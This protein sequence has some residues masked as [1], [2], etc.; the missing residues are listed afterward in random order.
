[1]NIPLP[2]KLDV[3]GNLA[4]NWK[5][6]WRMWDNYEIATKLKEQDKEQRISTLLV[7]IGAEAL[8]IYY[9][10]PWE[11]TVDAE[12]QVTKDEAR[13]IDVVLE[14]LEKYCTGETNEI[15]ERYCF[16][17][18]AQQENETIDA[19]VTALRTTGSDVQLQ[20]IGEQSDP[21]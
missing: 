20:H 10:L 13:D 18:R 1:M 14:K 11:V 19:Y 17:K 7:C 16:N 8:E 2:A 6:F 15:Y 21:R 5:K 3:S 12:G 4:T 9:G